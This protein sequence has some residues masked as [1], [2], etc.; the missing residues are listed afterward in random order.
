MVITFVLANSTDL[1]RAG[2]LP[3]NRVGVLDGTQQFHDLAITWRVCSHNQ[4]I[5]PTE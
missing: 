4:A 5:G 1:S 2:K 3:P